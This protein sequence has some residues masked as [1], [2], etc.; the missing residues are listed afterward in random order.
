MCVT[1]QMRVEGSVKYT[2]LELTIFFTQASELL[3]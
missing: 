1:R 2:V 3:F